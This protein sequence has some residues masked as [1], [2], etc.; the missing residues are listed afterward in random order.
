MEVGARGAFA[1]PVGVA[2]VCGTAVLGAPSPV[3]GITAAV[4]G[5]APGFW[6]WSVRPVNQFVMGL[7][8]SFVVGGVS[9]VHAFLFYCFSFGFSACYPV[10]WPGLPRFPAGRSAALPLRLRLDPVLLSRRQ[11]APPRGG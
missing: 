4:E 10:H 8:L 9:S 5:F 2:L 1:T 3:C 7:L 11:A 6:F